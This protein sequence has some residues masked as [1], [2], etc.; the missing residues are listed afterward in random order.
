M[1]ECGW[2]EYRVADLKVHIIVGGG[3]ARN[4]RDARRRQSGNSTR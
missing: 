4:Q 1:N 2:A 3:S